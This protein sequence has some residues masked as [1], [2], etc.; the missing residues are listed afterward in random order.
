[1]N[2]VIIL[3]PRKATIKF[4]DEGKG[5]KFYELATQRFEEVF[6]VSLTRPLP[7]P[8][9]YTR[10]RGKT[11]CPCCGAERTFKRDRTFDLMRCPICG[12]SDSY[13][14]TKVYNSE[15]F[16]PR[17][18]AEKEREK[19]EPKKKLNRLKN[20]SSRRDGQLR[21]DDSSK[22]TQSSTRARRNSPSL[23]EA[24]GRR[25]DDKTDRGKSKRGKGRSLLK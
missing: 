23:G 16:D 3:G 15:K 17:A 14:Y 25:R 8:I 13:F 12:I 21:E 11:W 24:K 20:H 6:M 5:K 7:P 18:Y 9:G 2:A 19:N 1:M 4:K 22:Q 10:S